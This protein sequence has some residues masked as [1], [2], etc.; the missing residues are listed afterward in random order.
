MPENRIPEDTI[1]LQ[2]ADGAMESLLTRMC[3]AGWIDAI[4]ERADQDAAVEF[5]F[6]ALGKKRFRQMDRI[7]REL[8]NYADLMESDE[9]S[10]LLAIVEAWIPDVEEQ[11]D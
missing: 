5:H 9:R 11:V 1:Q 3:R 7:M 4:I 2:T 8:G 10:E 6:T